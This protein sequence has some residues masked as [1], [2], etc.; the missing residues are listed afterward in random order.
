MEILI[1]RFRL[2]VAALVTLAILSLW[3][4][5]ARA[6]SEGWEPFPG[7]EQTKGWASPMRLGAHA[8][9]WRADEPERQVARPPSQCR[10]WQSMAIQL[11]ETFAGHTLRH[12]VLKRVCG[13]FADSVIDDAWDWPWAGFAQGGLAPPRLLR[14]IGA[15]DIRCGTA[16]N[17]RRC[18]MLHTSALPV[19]FDDA[20]AAAGSSQGLAQGSAQISGKS[21]QIVTHFVIDMVAGRES[22]LWRIFIPAAGTTSIVVDGAGDTVAIASAQSAVVPR[23]RD[24]NRGIRYR[25]GPHEYIERFSTC[26][27]NGCMMEAN[28]LH[29]GEVATELWDGHQVDLHVMLSAGSTVDVSLPS[30]GFRSA[31]AELVRLRREESRAGR[32]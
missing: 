23:A 13:N 30:K 12:T 16:G 19:D 27:A 18:A 4:Q 8:D 14:T 3:P 32:K 26:A 28:L 2:I 7:L 5:R 15:W 29:A 11:G 10:K 24:L 9:S 6:A 1:A 21:P 22:L 25:L 17:R 31:L 20:R